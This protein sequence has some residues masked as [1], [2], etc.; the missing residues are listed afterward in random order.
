MITKQTSLTLTETDIV[1]FFHL[2]L[3][4]L[5]GQKRTHHHKWGNNNNALAERSLGNSS[6]H[7]QTEG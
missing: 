7:K 6:I 5:L 1:V 2:P 3:V 4:F